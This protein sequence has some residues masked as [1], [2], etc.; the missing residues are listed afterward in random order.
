LRFAVKDHH[1][2]MARQRRFNE[3]KTAAWLR[4]D[5]HRIW[6]LPFI[7]LLCFAL[8]ACAGL[9]PRGTAGM[10]SHALTA[11]SAAAT[12]LGRV[13]AAS[14]KPPMPSGVQML[15]IASAAYATR[16]T[17]AQ[18][19]QR[20]IDLQTF[21]LH[22]DDTGKYLLDALAQAAARG[23]RVR[24]LVDDLHTVGADDLLSA[25]A[26]FDNVEV[27]LFNPFLRG[28]SSLAGKLL[29]SLNE[30]GRINHRMHNKL[31]VADNA[32][33]VFGG[34][35]TGDEY[36]MRGARA[37]FVDLDL[38]GAGA[39]VHDLSES[40]D[41]YWNS[42]HAFA[43]DTII[44]A[45]GS[46]DQRRAKFAVLVA[47]ALAPPP[48]TTVPP[49]LQR[50]VTAPVEIAAGRV[51]LLPVDA[52]VRADPVDKAGG[53]RIVDRAGTVRAFIGNAMGSAKDEVFVV[54]PY[55]VPGEIGMRVTQRNAARGVRLRLLTNSFAS[56]DEPSVYSGYQRYRKQLLE[57]GVEVYE[58]S[59]EL[60]RERGRLGR[61][62]P[63][64]GALHAKVVVIDRARLFVGSM[65]LDGRSER[66]N[67][68]LGVMIDSPELADEFLGMM[69]YASSAYRLRLSAGRTAIEWVRGD[70][71]EVL[72]DEPGMTLWQNFKARLLGALIPEDWL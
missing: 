18:H 22:A 68:E 6:H 12:P 28:R 53:S 16:L 57:A 62:G 4:A 67:T 47:D 29:G 45:G 23:V 26:S 63:S 38:L 40:F 59:P 50:Y 25:F 46:A 61:F 52:E 20:S 7:L 32:F 13:A 72:V 21:E 51:T 44:K 58:L 33:A 43:I 49:R 1:L 3:A 56:S 27:R 19:A 71:Q 70:T 54:S 15:P 64:L 34:R 5:T 39:L 35:N 11:S 37:N 8:G 60:A 48:D 24:L 31:F 2:P 65:N 17:L 42:E 41:A 69:D 36:F 66:Y 55:F 30:L 10:A 9:P 14:L